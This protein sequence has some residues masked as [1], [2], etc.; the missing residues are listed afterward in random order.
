MKPVHQPAQVCAHLGAS[1]ARRDSQNALRLSSSEQHHR[2]D[3]MLD[4]ELHAPLIQPQSLG[5]AAG[6]IRFVSKYLQQQRDPGGQR[7]A[8][9]AR[10]QSGISGEGQRG[11]K[12]AV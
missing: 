10:S 8:P 12:R 4:G 6:R 11:V 2:L 3:V 9:H 1:R 5:S 7:A